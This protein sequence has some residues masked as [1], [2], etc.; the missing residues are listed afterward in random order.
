MRPGESSS[1]RGHGWPRR[2]AYL[3]VTPEIDHDTAR[4][5]WRR[6]KAQMRAK[7]FFY[8][9]KNFTDISNSHR[10]LAKISRSNAWG[11]YLV[12]AIPL[13]RRLW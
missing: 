6:R 2:N 4:E 13:T 10:N 8:H 1:R 5:N 7:K 3:I 11:I 12:I 9:S